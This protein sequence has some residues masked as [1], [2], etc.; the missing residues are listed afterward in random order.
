MLAICS[1][2]GFAL[3]MIAIMAHVL[4]IMLFIS[5]STYK[6]VIRMFEDGILHWEALQTRDYSILDVKLL[7]SQ[8]ILLERANGVW[9]VLLVEHCI[10]G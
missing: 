5:V 7:L 1:Q 3:P 8:V 2:L 10:N 6:D 4:G 9:F